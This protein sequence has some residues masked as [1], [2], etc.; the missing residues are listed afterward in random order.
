MFPKDFPSLDQAQ[1]FL[2]E[3]DRIIHAP[4]VYNYL[5]R[6]NVPSVLIKGYGHADALLIHTTEQDRMAQAILKND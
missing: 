4:R 3:N 6:N 1:V 2:A 5:K